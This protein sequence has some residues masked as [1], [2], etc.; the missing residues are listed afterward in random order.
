VNNPIGMT[1]VF[2]ARGDIFSIPQ[3]GG[4]FPPPGGIIR[5][6]SFRIQAVLG[7]I[8]NSDLRL[9]L[10]IVESN[11]GPTGADRYRTSDAGNRNFMEVRGLLR[12]EL[13][14]AE[15][16]T[17]FDVHIDRIQSGIQRPPTSIS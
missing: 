14:G 10:E 11:D 13:V 2:N 15:A 5:T 16:T 8:G 6:D 7:N 9:R 3:G 4:E 12:R 1:N 17:G